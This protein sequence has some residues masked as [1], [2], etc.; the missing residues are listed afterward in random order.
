MKRSTNS[1]TARYRS[2]SVRCSGPDL[3]GGFG[4]GFRSVS[5]VWAMC[6]PILSAHSPIRG[7]EPDPPSDYFGSHSRNAHPDRLGRCETEV[8]NQL[9]VS[10]TVIVGHVP[11]STPISTT[12]NRVCWEKS[13]II[14]R[15]HEK[16]RNS[17]FLNRGKFDIILR[18]A[19]RSMRIALL[20][21]EGSAMDVP[22]GNPVTARQVRYHNQKYYDQD[23][24]EI[25]DYDYCSV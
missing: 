17:V 5:P 6:R 25:S 3:F 23:A 14:P 13:T 15:K 1:N 22:A 4:P 16:S 21:R 2:R 8:T 10:D 12:P 20:A 7:V 11:N 18:Y 19:G 9:V 24:P